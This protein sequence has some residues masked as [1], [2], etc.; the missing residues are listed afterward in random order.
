MSTCT[1]F[2]HGVA[3]CE[4]DSPAHIVRSC[5]AHVCLMFL[6]FISA[7]LLE[8]TNFISFVQNTEATFD[9][10]GFSYMKFNTAGYG[11]VV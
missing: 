1:L 4:H 9:S 2:E 11:G 3:W 5:L 7:C 8:M 6:F 10:D